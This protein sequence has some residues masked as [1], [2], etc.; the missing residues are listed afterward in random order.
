MLMGKLRLAIL[1][2]YD[3]TPN[4]GMR[5][6]K[7][8][9]H[10]FDGDLE[11]KLYDV[12]GKAEVPDL[13]YDLYI[14][15]GGPG[16]PHDGDGYWDVKYFD[17]LQSLWN[18][19][20]I[21]G[22]QKKYGFFICHSFQ[23]A[24]IHFRLGEVNKRKSMSFG[25]FKVHQTDAGINE[26]IFDGLSNPF[27]AADFRYWQVVG[28]NLDRFAEMGAQIL[29]LEKIR[30]HVPLE[31]AIMAIRFSPELLGVQFHPEADPE[32][33][34]THFL[35]PVR[36]KE[37]VEDHSEKKYL[38]MID[39]LSDPRKIGLTYEIVLPGFLDRAIGMLKRKAVLV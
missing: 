32:G 38:K 35:D 36:R 7:D 15:T 33:M 25:T 31:R 26:P 5:C 3:N 17:W 9:V 8:I 18:W 34:L 6:I 10:R 30:P 29:A 2:L 12:R 24:C 20:L 22:R 13:S 28:P 16:N 19:N 27:W 4:Q 23:M 14:S 11:W 37:I 1:D 39:D 21:P